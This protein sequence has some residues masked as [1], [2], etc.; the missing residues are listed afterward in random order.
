MHKCGKCCASCT[1]F[2]FLS[3]QTHGCPCRLGDPSV[4]ILDGSWHMP[5]ASEPSTTL[6]PPQRLCHLCLPATSLR[7]T[8]RGSALCPCKDRDAVA[9]PRRSSQICP[10]AHMGMRRQ[11]VTYLSTS[12]HRDAVADPCTSP[13]L[14]TCTDRDAVADPR[15]SSHICPRAQIEMR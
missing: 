14:S 6:P 7:M 3:S 13:D 12:T 1:F 4:R 9:D 5:N 11:I 8:G 2:I 15:R 10:C